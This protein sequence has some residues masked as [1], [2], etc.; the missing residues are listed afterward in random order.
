MGHNIGN[1]EMADGEIIITKRD[2]VEILKLKWRNTYCCEC[3]LSRVTIYDHLIGGMIIIRPLKLTACEPL[4]S[5]Y[6]RYGDPGRYLDV[7][8]DF[9]LSNGSHS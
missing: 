6:Q 2:L 7:A 5:F 3:G 4:L 8:I 1:V 9:T